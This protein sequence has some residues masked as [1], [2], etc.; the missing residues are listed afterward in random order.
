MTNETS[1]SYFVKCEPWLGDLKAT[2]SKKDINQQCLQI[3]KNT[4]AS[5]IVLLRFMLIYCKALM[6]PQICIV[7]HFNS[8]LSSCTASWLKL[9]IHISEAITVCEVVIH[10]ENREFEALCVLLFSESDFLSDGYLKHRTLKRWNCLAWE[11][12]TKPKYILWV[13][14]SKLLGVCFSQSPGLLR[15]NLKTMQL[16]FIWK[17]TIWEYTLHWNH[18]LFIW[19]SL[20]NNLQM[21]C[22]SSWTSVV[23][24]LPV[25]FFD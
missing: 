11:L 7:S 6:L 16:C 9:G 5:G 19:F 10:T 24:H 12:I 2:N 3:M 20:Q 17:C 25:I 1:L 18:T 15:F 13:I 22:H 4:W 23:I 21:C 14:S 8:D